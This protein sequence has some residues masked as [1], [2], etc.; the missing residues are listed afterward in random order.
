MPPPDQPTAPLILV[1][2]DDDVLRVMM[3]AELEEEGHEVVEGGYRG[4]R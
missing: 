2:D 4:R 3:R 1:V